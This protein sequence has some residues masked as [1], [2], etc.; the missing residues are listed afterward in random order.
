MFAL[1][2]SGNARERNEN[3]SR[4]RMELIDRGDPRAGTWSAEGSASAFLGARVGK[5]RRCLRTSQDGDYDV[6]F[7]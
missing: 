7:R 4:L 2:R 3:A 6:A 5:R 1:T